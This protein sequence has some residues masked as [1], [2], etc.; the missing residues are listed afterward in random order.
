[1]YKIYNRFYITVYENEFQTKKEIQNSYH[2]I[3]STDFH[4]GYKAIDKDYGPINICDIFK[5]NIFIEEKINDP[6]LIN[7]N[8]IYYVYNSYNNIELLNIVLLCG[9]YLIF[10]KNFNSHKVIFELS[11]IFNEHP[12]YYNDCISTWGGYKTSITDCFRTFEFIHKNKIINNF[13]IEEYEYL[14]D[15]Q[16]RD[17]NIIANKFLAMACPSHNKNINNIITELKYRKINLVIRLNGE[18]VYDKK[19]FSDEN[20]IVEDLYFPDCTVPD[21]TIIK[22]FMNLINNTNYN[23]LVAIHCKAGL[24]RTGLLIC[25]WLIIKLNFTPSNAITFIRL[26]RPGSIMGYQG[27]YLESYEYFREFI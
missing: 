25:I 10:N 27:F 14:T 20:I 12:C 2:Y 1:M 17:M 13:N 3:T 5:F 23:D 18:H 16:N 4:D 26:M 21:I 7:R 22:K 24:G 11:Q 9:A 19:L 6:K 15:F 8:I